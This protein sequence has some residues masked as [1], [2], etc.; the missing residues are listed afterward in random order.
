MNQTTA[1]AVSILERISFLWIS[2]IFGAVLGIA[3]ALI[4]APGTATMRISG[5]RSITDIFVYLMLI[6][7]FAVTLFPYRRRSPLPPSVD[8]KANRLS[9]FVH[10]FSGLIVALAIGFVLSNLT[11]VALFA[12]DRAF[13][14]GEVQTWLVVLIS[15]GVG[16]LAAHTLADYMSQ[17]NEVGLVRVAALILFSGLFIGMLLV[18]NPQ[19]WTESVS[20]LGGDPNTDTFFNTTIVVTG[21]LA[22]IVLLNLANWMNGLA[23]SERL[24]VGR[25]ALIFLQAAFLIIA[26]GIMMVGFF[27]WGLYPGYA[28]LHDVGSHAM[29]VAFVTLMFSVPFVL[30][31]YDRNFRFISLGYGWLA[32]L[33][34]VGLF[35]GTMVFAIAELLWFIVLALWLVVFV[36]NTYSALEDREKLPAASF[37][38]SEPAAN[39]TDA[40]PAAP[41]ELAPEAPTA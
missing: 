17:I 14:G 9:F 19:W 15:G 31:I 6:T 41:S 5:E 37:A 24:K 16:A 21:A 3:I 2:A 23:Q 26:V 12:L 38:H 11:R 33:I 18:E 34:G 25:S 4:I 39:A 13:I 36:R 20:F 32:I 10:R 27:P 28:L 1:P 35:T 30:P 8:P 22:G 29:L 7:G 40:D